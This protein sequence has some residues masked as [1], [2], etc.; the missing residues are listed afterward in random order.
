M[1]AAQRFDVIGITKV[2]REIVIRRNLA[3]AAAVER[4]RKQ[5]M[6]YFDDVQMRPTTART[7]APRDPAQ[8]PILP[9]R[10]EWVGGFTYI[11]DSTG[12][13]IGT[14]LGSQATRDFLAGL[15]YDAGICKDRA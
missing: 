15:L 4:V 13:K 6:T 2:G 14:L 9:L 12:R 1:T 5:D 3:E 7:G 8:L 11:V 10:I